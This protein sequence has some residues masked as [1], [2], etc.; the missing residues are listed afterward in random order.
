MMDE[1]LEKSKN[2]DQAYKS[3]LEETSNI[4][5]RFHSDQ[6]RNVKGNLN[7]AEKINNVNNFNN[8]KSK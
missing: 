7:N 5:E 2:E 1:N 4:I 3:Y 6:G 8:V